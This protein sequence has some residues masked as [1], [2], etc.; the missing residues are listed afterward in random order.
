MD[1]GKV[2][3]FCL[4]ALPVGLLLIG[5]A[6]VF[7][8]EFVL[9][10]ATVPDEAATKQ[11]KAAR[12]TRR[13]VAREDLEKY[14]NVLAGDIGE[15]HLGEPK[16]L[17]AAAYW[18]ESTLGPNNIGYPVSRERYQVGGE[19]VWN[20]VAELPG[21]R[22]AKEMVVVGAHYDT[23]P[24]CPGANDNGT[25][26]AALLSLAHSFAGETPDRTIRFVAF[27]NEEPPHFHTESMG[28]LVHARHLAKTGARVSAM[29]SLETIGFYSDEPG[30]QRTPPGLSVGPFPT[31]GNFVALVG[32]PESEPLVRAVGAAW[33]LA[34]VSVRA[35]P[36]ALPESVEG[37][38]WSDHWS[39]WQAGYPAVMVT[40]TAP[41]RYAHYHRPTDTPD[42]IDFAR[43]TDVVKGLRTVIESL[44]KA[45]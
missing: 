41:F 28:S 23:V 1:Q 4:V 10:D 2:I 15:R 14:V 43:Y 29:I 18:I 16:S 30:S 22:L 3:R 31:V 17:R 35:L 25:G 33:E 34:G 32:N 36:I 24:G 26:V 12:L 19:E 37:V 20:V 44:A 39:F 21:G 11:A 6:S 7:V 42:R 9:A 45:P 13:D 5:A 27:V 38:G 40:D 8:T